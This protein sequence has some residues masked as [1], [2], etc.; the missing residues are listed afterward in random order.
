MNATLSAVLAAAAT[1]SA[2]LTEQLG[3]KDYRTRDSAHRAVAAMAAIAHP[4][5]GL[6]S[7][8]PSAEVRERVQRLRAP[9]ALEMADEKS[10]RILPRNYGKMPWIHDDVVYYRLMYH[11]LNEA[12]R[13]IAK[14]GAP[15]WL[16]YREA[17]RLLVRSMIYQKRP[18]REILDMLDALVFKEIDWWRQRKGGLSGTD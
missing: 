2:G 6:A 13:T 7:D 17:T 16:E 12:R 18:R 15:E 11:Y 4:G 14:T 10:R 3:A 5:L 1:L 9:W 8:H